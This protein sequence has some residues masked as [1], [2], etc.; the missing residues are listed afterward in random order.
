MTKTFIEDSAT[1]G[2][3]GAMNV[4]STL[5]RT[6]RGG[7]MRH[8]D[9]EERFII[10][11]REVDYTNDRLE[12]RVIELA[13]GRSVPAILCALTEGLDQVWVTWTKQHLPE[14][15]Q[16]LEQRGFIRVEKRPRI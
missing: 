9:K 5:V 8:E 16:K 10:R 6:L 12:R 14:A 13:D 11:L 4:V 7:Q 3:S 2:G 15:S 1:K